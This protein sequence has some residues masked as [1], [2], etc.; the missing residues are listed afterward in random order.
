MNDEQK[1]QLLEC[2]DCN[3]GVFTLQGKEF[4][5]KVVNVYD[6]DTCRIVFFLNGDLVKYTVRLK[7]LDSPEIR[8]P[9]KDKYREYQIKEAKKS[10]NRLIQLCTDCDITI[11]NNLSKNKIQ[12]LINENKKIIK[13]KCEEFDKYG[14][15]LGNLYIN[16]N[17][18]NCYNDCNCICINDKLIEEGYAYKYDG[19][20]KQKFD[21]SKYIENNLQ[22]NNNNLQNDE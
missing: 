10:R 20:T 8:P 16:D 2:I 7:G 11:E 17:C 13:I 4:E 1:Q 9:S 19:G 21:Y 15:L 22:N 14:R 12:K 18:K 5:C 6:A 3:I